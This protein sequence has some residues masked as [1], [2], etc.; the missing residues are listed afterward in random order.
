MAV[1]RRNGVDVVANDVS[2]RQTPSAIYFAGDH[3]LIGEHSAGH[4]GSNPANLINNIKF[5]FKR[6][7]PASADAT[8]RDRPGG[9]V[10]VTPG[11]SDEGG[12]G[13]QGAREAQEEGAES[14]AA[15]SRATPRGGVL[16]GHSKPASVAPDGRSAGDGDE[17]NPPSASQPW[18]RPPFFCETRPAEDDLGLLAV[19]R[20]LEK[21]LELGTSEVIAYLLG[22]CAE[23]VAKDAGL[24]GDGEVDAGGGGVLSASSCLVASVPSYFTLK[25]KRAVLDAA[26]IAGV[27]MPMVSAESFHPLPPSRAPSLTPSPVLGALPARA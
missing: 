7:E 26:S 15:G 14:E 12:R 22:H 1:A 17:G 13:G 3:R 23:A 19:V 27:P 2:G 9:T 5:L 10:V 6:R 18:A 20:H 4:A 16:Q 25:Q 24:G 11:S 21:D 8:R